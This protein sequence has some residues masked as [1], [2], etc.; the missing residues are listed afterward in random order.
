MTI[1]ALPQEV[2]DAIAAG[3]VVER[4]ASVVKELVENALDA[5]A[6]RITVEV[7]GAGRSLV[8]VVDDGP[9]IPPE[10]LALAF[11][12]HATSKVATLGDLE[13][14]ATLGFRGE[15]L[16]SIAAVADV[17]CASA[18]SRIHLRAGRVE[19]EGATAPAPGTVVEVRDLFANTP[20]RLKFLKSE[21]TETSACLRVV[22]HFALLHPDLRFH[23][24]VD[25]RTVLQTDGGGLAAALRAVHGSPVAA[26]M[27][28][29]DWPGVDGAVSQPRLS[30]GNREGILLA[31]N[32]RPVASRVL[33]FAL[34]ECYRG[35]LER[36]RYPLAVL[37]LA[38]DPGSIDVNI[39]PA[40]RE[41]KFRD[42]GAVFTALQKAVRAA[43]AGSDSPRLT[44]TPAATSA[45]TA[46]AGRQLTLHET[47][48]AAVEAPATAPA[49][50]LRPLGQVLDGYLVAEGPDGLVLVDQ[51]AAH[52][53]VLFNRF[54]DRLQTGRPLSQALLLPIV[55][56][57][58]A[59][60]VAL[61]ADRAADVA[62]FGFELEP[63]GP[64]AVRILAGPVETPPD[65]V[66]AALGEVLAGLRANSLEDALAS[67]ACHSAVRF[68]D[69]LEPAE[70]RR[71]IDELQ[72][73]T[74]DAT[75]PHGR[76]TRL[77]LDWQE[78][79]RHFRRNY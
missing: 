71:L 28:A 40:K 23:C 34:E 31:V 15:A 6:R 4:P 36:G 22:Q 49:S 41:V 60:T 3:E 38:V 58:D 7:R 32:G 16:A 69:R 8:R 52:E 10:Q 56:E 27:L 57:L 59:A 67:L 35:S 13:A 43:L 45:A 20:A 75:C 33:A 14:I 11:Q 39:H 29:L 78:L 54:Q 79:K 24:A 2:A 5:G 68:G 72:S 1:R 76:P 48:V 50:P 47:A 51:H 12:R 77:L 55:V 65:R 64:R 17:E 44:V 37:D 21:A 26:S 70:Q 19:E 9:G 74:P 42:E 62:A 61:L 18:G 63:F 73:T 66:E 53:R 25:G 30:R 46:T